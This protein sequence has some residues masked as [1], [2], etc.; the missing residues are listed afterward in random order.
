MTIKEKRAR[1]SQYFQPLKKG[2]GGYL[3][4][5]SPIDDSGKPPVVVP[6]P[7]DPQEK[8]LSVDYKLKCA[9]AALQNNFY[10]QDAMP[11]VFVNFGPGVQAALLGAPY[12]LEMNSVWFDTDPPLKDWSNPPP[13]T[14]NL[15]HELQKS[16]EEHTRA[17]SAASK[18]RYAISL[19]DIGGTLDVLFSLRGEELL[20]DM[21]DYPD[22]IIK[23][24]E[25]LDNE[26][27]T[28]FNYLNKIIEPA[29]CGYTTWMPLV[30]DFPYYSIQCDFSAMISPAMFEK[31]ALPSLDKVST[32]IGC[33]IYHL[34]GPDEIPHLDML[35]SC[36]HIH[37]IQW[38]PL[39]KVKDTSTATPKDFDFADEMS[40]D[41]YRRAKA[42]GKKVAIF[43]VD[44]SQVEKIYEGAGSDGIFIL[45]ESP[46]RKGADELIADARR[47]W[48]KV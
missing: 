23:M 32:K 22:E 11:H 2:E 27:L 34:D 6:P 20:T 33:A 38:T 35:L 41:V 37:A 40:L 21:Y 48:L 18:G 29:N 3:A 47:H 25:H 12:K 4:V 39:P 17:F 16:I 30:S 26:F 43:H 31:F 5:L 36:K 8:W 45:A 15:N 24:Q 1:H 46:T 10:G 44:P 19:T 7:K 9:E 28:Y 42:A 13:I 14:T